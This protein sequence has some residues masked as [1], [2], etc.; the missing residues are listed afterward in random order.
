MTVTTAS[1]RTGAGATSSSRVSARVHSLVA[2]GRDP[3]AIFSWQEAVRPGLAQRQRKQ[4]GRQRSDD[5][6]FRFK[7]HDNRGL[8]NDW[9]IPLG[10]GGT[11]SAM[12]PAKFTFD[13]NAAPDC[14]NDFIVYP[15]NAAG[16]ATQPNLVAF[17]NLYSGTVGGAGIC[18]RGAPPAGDDGVSATTL[19]SYNIPA[20]GGQVTTSPALSLDGTKVAFVETASG[21]TAHFHVLAWRSGDGVDLTTPNA[22]NVLLP[23]TINS[24]ATQ[25]PVAGSGNRDGPGPGIDRGD[26]DT[27]SSPFVDYTFDYAYIGNDNG[28]LFRVQDVFCTVNPACS[29][30]T[31]PAPSLD[32]TWGTAGALSVC[33]GSRMSGPVEDSAP[34][35]YLSDARTASCTGLPLTEPR[36]RIPRIA[37][38]MARRREGLWIRRWWTR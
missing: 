14:T 10:G 11:S 18:N 33:P 29:G 1:S 6:D 22:Q 19:W 30:G 7:R 25:S 5:H 4:G 17:N 9:S 13:V 36:S 27:L 35:T 24:F 34:D 28:T 21:T 37:W 15:V 8:H 31:P 23:V 16:S 32:A 20:A 38:E 2:A 3:R 12:Y 26:S